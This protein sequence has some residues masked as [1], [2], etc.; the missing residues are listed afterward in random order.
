MKFQTKLI[1]AVVLGALGVA[2]SAHAVNL[3]DDGRGE[4]LLYP[5]YTTQAGNDTLISLVNTTAQGKVVKI[6]VLES[7]NSR[8]VIDFN[9]Y[10]SANDAW[11]AVITADA[12]TGGAKLKTFDKSCTAPQL[13]A[14]AD[15]AREVS[16][17]NFAYVAPTADNGPAGLARTKEGYIEVIEMGTVNNNFV[18]TPGTVTFGK[19]ITH[20]AGVPG[21]CAAVSTAWAA[22]GAFN[23]A[24]GTTDNTGGLIGS[25]SIINVG[26]GTDYSF[27]PVAIEAFNRTAGN[28]GTH[29]APGSLLPS[30][31]SVDTDG[32]GAAASAIFYPAAVGSVV[33]VADWNAVANPVTPADAVS[34]VL[35]RQ[36][37]LN[38]FTVNPAIGGGTDMVVTFPTKKFYVQP[39]TT[40]TAA[41]VNRPFRTNFLATG[42]TATGACEPVGLSIVGREE[43]VPVAQIDFSPMPASGA[44][45]LCWEA[46][47]VTLTNSNVL[48]SANVL[49]VN[50]PYLDGWM[51]MSFTTTAVIAG[52]PAGHTGHQM[53]ANGASG[54]LPVANDVYNGLPVIGFGVQKYVN[55]N[56]GGV[57][58]NYG[59]AFIHKY[60]RLVN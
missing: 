40:F 17:R 6:R 46:N 18:L 44:N 39:A 33:T 58:S 49:N 51:S 41:L 38:E 37:V 25:A 55:G 52:A 53:V 23:V 2:T 5:Y 13:T 35:M 3:G 34:A 20:V 54:P 16:F 8:E 24:T 30:L 28:T 21:D 43:E 27:D 32:A 48:G 12:A 15:G 45:T 57:L 47:V 56:V 19:A 14:T 26:A 22:G 42:G 10:L 31:A 9:L 1:H 36:S 59:G 7:L 4:V 60:V 11:S 50:S 29:T